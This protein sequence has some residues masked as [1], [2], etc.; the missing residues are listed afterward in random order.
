MSSQTEE[1]LLL[2]IRHCEKDRNCR[3]LKKIKKILDSNPKLINIHFIPYKYSLLM[4][5]VTR[6]IRL[7][8]LLLSYPQNLN[9]ILEETTIFSFATLYGT[10]E[11]FE[12]LNNC[13]NWDNEEK[14]LDNH[15]LTYSGIDFFKKELNSLNEKKEWFIKQR[16]IYFNCLISQLDILIK[17]CKGIVVKYI[18]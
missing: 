11:H 10:V 1:K 5:S 17:N 3:Q 18:Y 4:A 13:H 7:F 8:K 9:V 15:I 12:L 6:H 14:I 2:L 16:K